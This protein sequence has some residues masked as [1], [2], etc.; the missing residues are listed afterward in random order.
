MSQRRRGED[1]RFISNFEADRLD[2]IETSLPDSDENFETAD[3]RGNEDIMVN[4]LP[5]IEDG[6]NRLKPTNFRCELLDYDNVKDW[7]ARMKQLL[8]LQQCWQVMEATMEMVKNKQTTLLEEAMENTTWY[9]SNLLAVTHI[10]YHIYKGRRSISH[11]RYNNLRRSMDK[12]D[13]EI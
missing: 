2:G 7:K 12:A 13:G 1:G 10:N 9:T 8:S 11:S 3:E 4:E 6:L 5:S